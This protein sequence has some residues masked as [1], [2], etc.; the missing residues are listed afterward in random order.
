MKNSLL[1][2]LL[3]VVAG[4]ALGETNHYYRREGNHVQHLK[5]T[6]L[7][8]DLR[9]AMDVDFEPSGADEAGSKAC[10]AEI[11]GDAKQVGT[12]EIVFKK[13][14][15]GEARYCELKIS[16]TAEDA[17]VQQSPDCGYFVTGICHFESEGKALAKL[18]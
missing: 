4:N 8:D 9:V 12:G 11:S 6:R 3:L 13:Q 15:E 2:A 5:I 18:K 7:G 14:A 1:A 17:K 16:L 10:S